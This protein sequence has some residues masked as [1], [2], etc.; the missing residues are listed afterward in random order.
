MPSVFAWSKATNPRP[1]KGR[2]TENRQEDGID[3]GNTNTGPESVTRATSSLRS[4]VTYSTP[5]PVEPLLGLNTLEALHLLADTALET[6]EATA[7]QVNHSQNNHSNI[8]LDTSGLHLLSDACDSHETL[9][10]SYVQ[11]AEN[12]QASDNENDYVLAL[13]KE[14]SYFKANQLN[15][16]NVKA[17]RQKLKF[18]TGFIHPDLFDICF[19]FVTEGQVAEE[20]DYRLPL[21][22]QFL[23]VLV[24]LRL[25]LTEQHISYSF[26][27]HETIS[28]A[29]VSRIFHRWIPLMY[30]RFKILNIWPSREQILNTVPISVILKHP[31]L[32]VI[33]DCTEITI[34]QPRGPANQQVTFS[35]YKNCNTAK[36]LI[37]VSPTGAISFVSELYGGN[38]SDKEI[39]KR[40]GILKMMERGDEVMADRGFLIEDLVRPYGIRLNIPACTGGRSH[41]EPCEVTQSRRVASTRIHVE[42]AIGRIK[43]FKILTHVHSTYVLPHLNEIFFVCAMLTNFQEQLIK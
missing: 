21:V 38:I 36:A 31:S 12:Q 27:A 37:G 26:S 17:N 7:S 29:T 40:S 28:T 32:R 2:V 30:R 33:I 24:R 39:T 18:Y 10:R 23:L 5:P 19:D 41:L 13:E 43:E 6:G 8:D 22:E 16:K 3:S 9:T 15:S 20:D 11:T 25:G 34:S 1:T 4:P 14:P 42:R 35:N